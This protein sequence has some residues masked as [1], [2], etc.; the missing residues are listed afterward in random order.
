MKQATCPQGQVTSD[1]TIR[2]D[3]FGN[4]CVDVRFDRA[5][6]ADC[7]KRPQC[8]R[9]KAGPR[10]IMMRPQAQH[11]LLQTRRQQQATDTWRAHYGKRAGIEGTLSQ[12]IRAFGLRR[13]RY[14]GLP[15]TRFQHVVTA[16]AMNVARIDDWLTG[17]SF[18]KT[19]RSAF[20]QMHFRL[21]SPCRRNSAA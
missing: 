8:T 18:A 6:C 14:I 21:R 1:W 19:R 4:D 15:K 11:K 2:R 10:E 12:G 20:A 17:G 3:N 5:T 13:C 16:L 7:F 9:S